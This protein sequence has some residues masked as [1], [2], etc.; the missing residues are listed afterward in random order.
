MRGMS[1]DLLRRAF[2]GQSDIC[3]RFGSPF[4]AALTAKVA[5]DL[6]PSVRSLFAPWE[7]R[8]LEALVEAAVTLRFLGAVHDLARSGDCPDLS[9]SFPPAGDAAR[10]WI[11]VRAAIEADHGR[12]VRFMAHEPQTNE[13][14]R[15]AC[16]LPGFLTIAQETRLPLACF[17][18]GASAG[19]NQLWWRYGY[20]YGAA[21]RWGDPHS[22]LKLTAEWTGPAPPIDAPLQLTGASA[23]DRDP[24][25]ISDPAQR[26]R[27]VAYLWPDQTDRLERFRVASEIAVA[28]GV[29]VERADAAAW[30]RAK[31]APCDGVATVIYHSIIW[32]YLS[33]AAQRELRGV[34]EDHGA[35]AAPD[36]PLAWLRMEPAPGQAFPIELW[37]TLWP[38]GREQRLA[39][40]HAHGAQ[41]TWEG[42]RPRSG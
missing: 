38:G 12:F 41:V 7:G 14:R 2:L 33:S 22:P 28:A 36:A 26:G 6:T 27:L 24:I 21:G 39:I 37:L 8:P 42:W 17:E 32:Q 11:A 25:D 23:C 13:V 18:L 9:A 40:A 5:D 30:A 20:D 29:R 1:D 16:L 35:G 10:A 31:A 19:L 4:Y 3:A 15:S 34:I